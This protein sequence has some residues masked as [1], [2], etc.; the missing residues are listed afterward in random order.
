MRLDTLAPGDTFQLA[1]VKDRRGTLL[2]VGIS[3]ALVR[4][5][6][7]T[8]TLRD[9]TTISTSSEPVTISLA[10]EVKAP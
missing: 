3:G 2:R 9:G 1:G 10:T 5:Q 8:T 7:S 4:Y 6:P